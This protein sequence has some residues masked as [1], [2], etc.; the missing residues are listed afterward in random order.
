MLNQAYNVNSHVQFLCS[1]SGMTGS[2][3]QPTVHGVI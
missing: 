2:L 1:V 3:D